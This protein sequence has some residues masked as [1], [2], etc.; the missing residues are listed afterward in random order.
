MCPDFVSG[1]LNPFPSIL[2][3]C[4]VASSIL[5]HVNFVDIPFLVTLLIK[6]ELKFN[7]VV[8]G[9]LPGFKLPCF[10]CMLA[11]KIEFFMVSVAHNLLQLT[12]AYLNQARVMSKFQMK[13]PYSFFLIWLRLG[14]GTG[15]RLIS[16]L[17][18]AFVL[19]LVVAQHVKLGIALS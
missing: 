9:E 14:P 17:V 12:F 2:L 16:V 3:N 18:N 4:Q 7:S 19:S 5:H 15:I 11:L 1:F 8:Q 13:I 10:N 6:Q